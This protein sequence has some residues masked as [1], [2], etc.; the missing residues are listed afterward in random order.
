M[1]TALA[2]YIPFAMVDKNGMA[3]GQYQ[4]AWQQAF[5]KAVANAVAAAQAATAAAN[6]QTSAN[7]AQGTANGAV[8]AASAAQTTANGALGLA[9]TA[10]QQKVGPTWANATG[11][12][13]RTALAAFTGTSTGP[14]TVS[15]PPTQ[16]E[17]QAIGDALVSAVS[18][19]STA[20]VAVSQHEV[21]LINDLYANK[22]LTN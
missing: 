19:L 9:T 16:A 3:T 1:S 8:T 2:P 7:G 15:N 18:A 22:A 4:I 10:V 12:A 6:A 14:F 21:A 5:Q 20:L 11:T 17:V 13:D